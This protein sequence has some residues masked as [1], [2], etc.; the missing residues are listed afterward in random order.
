MLP[1]ATPLGLLVLGFLPR[2]ARASQPWASGRNPFGID[3][4]QDLVCALM[5]PLHP[6]SD[7]LLNMTRRELFKRSGVALGAAALQWL[8]EGSSG[9][10]R[11]EADESTR[12]Q[13]PSFPGTRETR[14]LYAHGGRAVAD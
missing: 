8:L 13:T 1:V 5:N 7:L 9:A 4:F 10:A 3:R 12:A 6:F 14:D 2:V 11:N